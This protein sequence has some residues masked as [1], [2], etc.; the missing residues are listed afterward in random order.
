MKNTITV[1]KFEFKHCIKSKPFNSILII[2][3]LIAIGGFIYNAF[4]YHNYNITDLRSANEITILNGN[5]TTSIKMALLLIL[6]LVS[7]L[8]YSSSFLVDYNSGMYKN[9]L[10]RVTFKSYLLNKI[11]VTTLLTFGTFF[12]LF[13]LNELLCIITFPLE[14]IANSFGSPSFLKT[15][16][17]NAFLGLTRLSNPYVF[18]FIMIFIYSLIASMHA[19]VA[20]SI[21]LIFKYKKVTFIITYFIVCQISDILFQSIGIYKYHFNYIINSNTGSFT[22]LFFWIICA[23]FVSFLSTRIALNKTDIAL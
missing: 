5:K 19:L 6:P 2:F 1:F 12:Y 11:L 9:I 23:I 4:F 8:I 15:T 17:P 7:T 20:L 21:S 18:D 13:L 16:L 10:S 3:T 22:T 14:G